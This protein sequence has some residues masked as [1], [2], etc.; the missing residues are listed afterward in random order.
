VKVRPA[1]AEEL[2][3]VGKLTVAAYVADG[4]DLGDSYIKVLADAARRARDADLLVA[5][6][7][8]DRLLG[9]VT[10]CEPGTPWAEV[11]RPG[12]LEFRMLAVTPAARGRGIGEGLTRAVVDRARERGVHQVVLCSSDYMDVAHRLYRRLGF[13]RLPCRDWQP[14]PGLQLL[15]FALELER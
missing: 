4:M 5:V 3:A 6:D 9:T 13:T 11:S 15:A 10:V 8:D 2:D 14:V 12:E 7:A 1:R